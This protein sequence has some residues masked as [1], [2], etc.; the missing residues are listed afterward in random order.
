MALP[1]WLL[2][3]AL[4][5]TGCHTGT[6]AIP[7]DPSVGAWS[8]MLVTVNA[9]RAEGAVCGTKRMPPAP[10]L[11]WDSRLA[12]AA[13]QHARDMAKHDYFAHY[14]RD[15]ATPGD[16]ARR[17]GYAWRSVAENIARRQ[18][19]VDEVVQDWLESPGH[20]RQLLDPGFLEFGAAE[21]DRHWAQ[22]FG[23]PS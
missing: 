12:R 14:G 16:R 21:Y 8:E 23:I 11:R 19:T 7:T 10:P 22:V 1:H 15:G 17:A 6:L 20:C 5:C 18:H 3:A 9:V 2:L 13:G 4:S